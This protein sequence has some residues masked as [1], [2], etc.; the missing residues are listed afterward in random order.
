MIM[1]LLL[2]DADCIR[3]RTRGN[4]Q[5]G[6][7]EPLDRGARLFESNHFTIAQRYGDT[8]SCISIGCI[9]E[10]RHANNGVVHLNL[11]SIGQAGQ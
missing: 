5:S 10:Q 7:S 11:V 3:L 8:V 4:A 2:R 9:N 6:Q 1:S